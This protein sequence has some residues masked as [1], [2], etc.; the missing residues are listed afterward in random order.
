MQMTEHLVGEGHRMPSDPFPTIVHL[1][2]SLEGGGTERTLVALLSRFDPMKLRH[3]VVTQRSA[4]AL[5]SEL[6]DHVSCRP[7]GALG[8][9]RYTAIRLGRLLREWRPA[10]I[11]ARNTGSWADAI[12]ATF[13]RR[14]TRLLLGFHGLETREPFSRRQQRIAKLGLR[15][16]AM[17]TSVSN[18]GKRQLN[19]EARIP[20][21][22][23]EVLANGVDLAQYGARSDAVR[24]GTRSELG[25]TGDAIVVG[26]VGSLTSVKGHKSIIRAVARASRLPNAVR[27]VVVGE[28]PLR[29]ELMAE[30]RE[31]GIEDLVVFTGRREDLPALYSGMDVF[32]CGSESE[33]MNNAVLEAAAMGLPIVATDVGDNAEV[34]RDNVEGLIVPARDHRMM[35]DALAMLV[36]NPVLRGRLGAAARHRAADYDFRHT[37]RSYEEF[38]L[39]HSRVP[40]C[41]AMSD[42]S[43]RRIHA[44]RPVETE[45]RPQQGNRPVIT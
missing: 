2:H 24:Y 43:R 42:F 23:V 40:Q 34:I 9:S 11:H 45:S 14:R 13:L 35:G 44:N 37:V 31:A 10:V 41:T 15:A 16:G 3:I 12:I 28:G 1:V 26:T 19:N 21:E 29:A 33:G 39:S 5:S 6:P 4:G 7:L 17:F 20:L 30:A 38:Y 27:L 22:Q 32:V 18:A 8:R 25:I 36:G